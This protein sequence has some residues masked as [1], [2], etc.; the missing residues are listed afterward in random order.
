MSEKSSNRVHRLYA[1]RDNVDSLT[2]S[3]Q[4]CKEMLDNRMKRKFYCSNELLDMEFAVVKAL[5]DRERAETDSPTPVSIKSEQTDH[6]EASTATKPTITTTNTVNV[7]GLYDDILKDLYVKIAN[8]RS[9]LSLTPTVMFPNTF[10]KACMLLEVGFRGLAAGLFILAT[11]VLLAIP[12]IIFKHTIDY[13]C[14][15]K[16]SLYKPQHQ[17]SLLCKRFIAYGI[18]LCVG[19]S[20]RCENVDQTLL[21]TN[22]NANRIISKHKQ[23]NKQTNKHTNKRSNGSSKNRKSSNKRTINTSNSHNDDGIQE[24]SIVCFSH[25]CAM[26]VFMFAAAIPVRAHAVVRTLT[27]GSVCVGLFA[28][29][30][31]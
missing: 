26:D 22:N 4:K 19:L 24:T 20:L 15:Y 18:L 23:S 12:S 16:L 25:T 29:V 17:L 8:N 7:L 9:L 13:V 30:C 1:L 21:G 5:F 2:G 14:V 3:I 31:V 27:A 11:S 10:Y 28:C 6:P